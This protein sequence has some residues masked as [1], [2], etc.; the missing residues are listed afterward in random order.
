MK[1]VHPSFH[2]IFKKLREILKNKW[3]LETLGWNN[4]ISVSFPHNG[5]CFPHA[6]RFKSTFLSCVNQYLLWQEFAVPAGSGSWVNYSDCLCKL[7]ITNDA[8]C[9]LSQCKSTYSFKVKLRLKTFLTQHSA[10]QYIS[11]PFWITAIFF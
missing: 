1:I 7:S 10:Y 4:Y 8:T 3:W 9:F 2:I 6:Y 11:F 5:K